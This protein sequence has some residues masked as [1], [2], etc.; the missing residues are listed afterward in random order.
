MNHVDENGL[1]ALSY[2]CRYLRLDFVQ[3]LLPKYTVAEDVIAYN[4]LEP[5]IQVIQSPSMESTRTLLR[6]G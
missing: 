4:G 1:S 5:L 2:D 3:P 6:K